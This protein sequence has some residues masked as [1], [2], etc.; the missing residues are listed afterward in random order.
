MNVLE[1]LETL[2]ELKREIKDHE[3]TLAGKKA[4]LEKFTQ[5]HKLN[6]LTASDIIA[7]FIHRCEIKEEWTCSSKIACVRALKLRYPECNLGELK[8]L[9][10]S[11][12]NPVLSIL[13]RLT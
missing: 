1:L 4:Q 13:N 10:D 2:G 6:D 9:A 8:T 12:I 5:Q 11:L 7:Q 3:Y